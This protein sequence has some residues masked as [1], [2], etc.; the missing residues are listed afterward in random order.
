V[1]T[2]RA[3]GTEGSG[4]KKRGQWHCFDCTSVTAR[5]I[6]IITYLMEHTIY[7]QEHVREVDPVS[8]IDPLNFHRR[9]ERQWAERI[10]SLRRMSGQAVF[11]TKRTLR[12]AINHDGPLIPVSVRTVLGRQRCGQYR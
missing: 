10:K 1:L 12:S 7:V 6:K 9:I 2:C 8:A 4:L 3:F 11:A 5:K